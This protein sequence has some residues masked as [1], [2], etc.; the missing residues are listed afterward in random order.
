VTAAAR[1]LAVIYLAQAAAGIAIG[2]VYAVW[3]MYLT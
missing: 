1:F 3:T 2:I